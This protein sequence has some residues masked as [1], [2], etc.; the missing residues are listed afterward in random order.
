MKIFNKDQSGPWL[1]VSSANIIR[2]YNPLYFSIILVAK[3][4]KTLI[5]HNNKDKLS[6]YMFI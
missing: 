6:Y 4:I 1:T 2:D 3:F 5:I